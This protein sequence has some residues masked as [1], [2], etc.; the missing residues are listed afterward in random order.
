MS[1]KSR[2]KGSFKKQ[3]GKCAQTLFKFAWQNLY[4]IY[5]S[6]WRQL[7]FKKFLSVI[8]KISRLF[9][10]TLSADG[11][12]SLLNRDNLTQPIQM[13]LYWKQKTFSE[14]FSAFLKSCLNFEHFQKKKMTFI[15]NVFPKL[16][17]PKNLVR[18]IS[19]K[20]R[21]KGS[22]GKQHGKRAQTLLK[23]AWQHLY[24]IYWLLWRQ[25]TFKKSL[26]VICKISRLFPNTLSADGKYSLLNRDNL[27]Q[28]IQMQLS[29]KQK[30]FSD[31]FSA[32]LKSNWHFGCLKEKMTLIGDVFLKLQPPKNVV[33]STSKKSRLRGSFEK[34]H[35][36]CAQTLLKCQGQLLYHIYWSRWK[37]LIW[38]KSLLVTC[39]ISRLF[40]K[41]LSADG[42]YSLLNRDNLTQPIE[43]EFS[44][45][46]KKIFWFFFCIFEI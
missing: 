29:R 17:T 31:F 46:K 16:R 27:T 42:K 38:K 37:E 26:L 30:S 32:F 20:S 44:R 1:I 13:Q 7:N 45:K 21:F 43:M 22:F 3:H 9:P 28:P 2:F 12:Y 8:C 33:R 6:L 15:A 18:S 40:P 36:K 34:Q 25:L 39:K 14:F 41:T 24:H 23:F 35:G 4:H 19:K 11:K 10:N 5:W